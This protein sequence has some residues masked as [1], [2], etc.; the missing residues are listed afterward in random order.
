MTVSYTMF[1]LLVKDNLYFFQNTHGSRPD[2]QVL[3]LF[4]FYFEQ[5]FIDLYNILVFDILSKLR[6][7]STQFLTVHI[8]TISKCCF[9]VYGVKAF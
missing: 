3:T 6:T 8:V 9:I 5:F 2:N 4:D 1:T 7:F